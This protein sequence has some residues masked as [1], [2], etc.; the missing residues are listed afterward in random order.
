MATFKQLWKQELSIRLNNSDTTAL[1][2]STRRQQALHEAIE[3]FADLTE[4]LTRTSTIACSCNVTEYSLLASTSL[5]NSTDYVRLA[6]QGVEY[7]HTSSAGHLTHLSGEDFPRR[8]LDWRN[9][10]EAGWRTST[11]PVIT[12]SGYFVREDGGNVVIGLNEPPRV[13]SSETAVILVPYVLR[14]T[15]ITSSAAEPFTVNGAVRTDLRTYHKALP[16]FASYKLKPLI[17]DKEG[18]AEDLQVFLGYVAR[19]IQNQRA[20]GGTHVTVGRS[21]FRESQVSRGGR[22]DADPRWARR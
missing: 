20:K 5:Q 15:P 19:C 21:Y 6:K 13:G 9:R 12:P 7:L 1:F 4:C 11:T 17:G 18:A 16:Y 10:Y 22:P 14:P 3:E 2:T 8:D